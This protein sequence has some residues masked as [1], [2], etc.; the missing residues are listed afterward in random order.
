MVT[1]RKMMLLM[2]HFGTVMFNTAQKQN[3]AKVLLIF[4][5]LLPFVEE[6]Y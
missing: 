6:A 2:G 3:F 4:P 1:D 5:I